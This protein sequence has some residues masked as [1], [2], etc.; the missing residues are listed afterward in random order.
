MIGAPGDVKW[1]QQR[2]PA[3]FSEEFG[4]RAVSD[5]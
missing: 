2:L 1:V 5:F 3:V 4:F